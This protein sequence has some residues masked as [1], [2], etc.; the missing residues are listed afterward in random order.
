MK[1]HFINVHLLVPRS[2]SSAKVKVKYKGYISQQMAVSGAFVFH[3]HIL[4]IIWYLVIYFIWYNWKL[5]SFLFFFFKEKSS[6]V[7]VVLFT[8]GEFDDN[9]GLFILTKCMS[10]T[11]QTLNERNL[12]KTLWHMVKMQVTSVFFFFLNVFNPLEKRISFLEWYLVCCMEMLSIWSCLKCCHLI[13][14]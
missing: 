3:K 4:F 10:N 7:I 11:I 2:R 13:R 5:F 6:I 12:L 1:A 14:G 9:T 8:A